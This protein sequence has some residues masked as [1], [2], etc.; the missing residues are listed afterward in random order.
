MKKYNA[1][2]YK[3]YELFLEDVN[4]SNSEKE[5]RLKDY[6]NKINSYNSNKNKFKSILTKDV[7][8]WEEEASKII[9]GNVYLS[10]EWKIAK[11]QKHIT[12]IETE[13]RSG[14]LSKEEIKDNQNKLKELKSELSKD[15][16]DLQK[17]I[18]D[19]L[20]KIQTS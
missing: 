14:E 8:V 20:H 18:K 3:K 10:S 12:D 6:K 1:I 19:D 4:N 11:A 15:Q 17:H 2:N 16:Q 7:S 13:I 5:V 9:D